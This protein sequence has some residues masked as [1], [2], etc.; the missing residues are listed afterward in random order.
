MLVFYKITIMSRMSY[1]LNTT[2]RDP[3]VFNS[4]WVSDMEAILRVTQRN[5]YGCGSANR[6]VRNWQ[7]PYYT[8]GRPEET[9]VEEPLQE[10]STRAQNISQPPS[11]PLRTSH[12]STTKL[13]ASNSRR[14]WKRPKKVSCTS[15]PPETRALLSLP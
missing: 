5:L 10:S 8:Q 9:K 6:S 12:L 2:Q 4:K 15:L 14:S 11:V 13:S 7:Q 1:T 3:G